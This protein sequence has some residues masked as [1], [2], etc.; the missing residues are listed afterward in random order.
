[1]NVCLLEIYIWFDLFQLKCFYSLA[2]KFG[3]FY[4]PP[5][6]SQRVKATT[7]DVTKGDYSMAKCASSTRKDWSSKLW[8]FC[9]TDVHR[10]VHD[11]LNIQYNSSNNCNIGYTLCST[12][13]YVWQPWSSIC[14]FCTET[15]HIMFIYH[16]MLR[17]LL[18]TEDQLK[19]YGYG[20][21]AHALA[22]WS[23]AASVVQNSL[24]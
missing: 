11:F 20:I 9:H 7:G 2:L 1:V 23:W 8:V 17:N 10:C 4:G 14:N 5:G 19:F 12:F 18:Q 21:L 16:C 15:R 22:V 13:K 3:A 6:M 24:E